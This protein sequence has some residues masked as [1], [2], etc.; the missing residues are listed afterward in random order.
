MKIPDNFEMLKKF[1]QKM[2]NHRKTN[3]KIKCNDLLNYNEVKCSFKD[4]NNNGINMISNTN[5]KIDYNFNNVKTNNKENY[6]ERLKENKKEKNKE[7]LA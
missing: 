2:S 3:N 5:K 6:N 4:E 7:S 1:S